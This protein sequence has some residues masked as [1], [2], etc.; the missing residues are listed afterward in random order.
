MNE[1]GKIGA[2]IDL[3]GDGSQSVFI[4]V[5]EEEWAFL[6][7]L[8]KQINASATDDWEITMMLS[9]TEDWDEPSHDANR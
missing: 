8:A 3:E 1:K 5:T 7:R 2:H 4:E 9:R 6:K